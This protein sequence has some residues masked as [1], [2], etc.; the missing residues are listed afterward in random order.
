MTPVIHRA[1]P[2]AF[3]VLEGIFMFGVAI[4]A[5]HLIWAFFATVGPVGDYPVPQKTTAPATEFVG[6]DAVFGFQAQGGDT[7]IS[8]SGI[9]LFG[10]RLNRASGQGSAILA[11]PAEPQRSYRVGEEIGP[12]IALSSVH[13]DHVILTN[14]GVRE[15]I[16]I[17]QSR[18]AAP[19]GQGT[20]E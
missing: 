19:V 20:G 2:R 7:V 11:L 6:L 5:A 13:F 12:G 1:F 8:A 16:Y 15:A 17:D 14:R 10:L 9:E 3:P 4:A 18:P